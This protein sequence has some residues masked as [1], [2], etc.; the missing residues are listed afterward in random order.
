[1]PCW[2]PHYAQVNSDCRP[3][4]NHRWLRR[5][6]WIRVGG[7][8]KRPI[9]GCA[10]IG[11]TAFCV[12]RTAT[13]IR[14]LPITVRPMLPYLER[15]HPT[16]LGPPTWRDLNGGFQ[17]R[18]VTCPFESAGKSSAISAGRAG[19]VLAPIV[20]YWAAFRFGRRNVGSAPLRTAHQRAQQEACSLVRG[21]RRSVRSRTNKNR[22]STEETSCRRDHNYLSR[23]PTWAIG[24]WSAFVFGAPGR[25]GRTICPA[26]RK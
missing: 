4:S 12:A 23:L 19:K 10:V 7:R 9:N 25:G 22:I 16:H 18:T 11:M 20:R 14:V 21:L 8:A 17:S 15:Q 26:D 5:C 24:M 6:S 3:R 2:R 13:I 1:M